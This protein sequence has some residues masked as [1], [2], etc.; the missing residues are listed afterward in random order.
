MSTNKKLIAGCMHI[1]HKNIYHAHRMFLRD[2]V[3]KDASNKIPTLKGWGF[4]SYVMI[5]SAV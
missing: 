3:V 5:C 1:N 4:C 2:L